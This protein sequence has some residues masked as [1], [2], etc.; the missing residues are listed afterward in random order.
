MAPNPQVT[1]ESIRERVPG[2]AVEVG[3]L[4]LTSLDSVRAFAD[5]YLEQH[6]ELQLLVNN[7]G[8]MY[9]PFERTAEGFEARPVVVVAETAQWATIRAVL[10]PGERIATRGVLPLLAALANADTD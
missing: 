8:V 7:A 5:W 3:T 6:D 1:V 2:A 4:D 10:A 9:T